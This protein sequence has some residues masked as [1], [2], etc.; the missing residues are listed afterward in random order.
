MQTVM[1]MEIPISLP[2]LTTPLSSPLFGFSIFNA[3]VQAMN[4]NG[5]DDIPPAGPHRGHYD[6]FGSEFPG[7][8]E[9]T[10]DS[11]NG[12]GGGYIG[13]SGFGDRNSVIKNMG[14]FNPT[15]QLGIKPKDP[16]CVPWPSK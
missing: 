4:A 11:G 7:S 2:I 6:S 8:L 3:E 1:S 16:P 15:F 13:Q 5:W 9:N 12:N 10:Q 14:Q